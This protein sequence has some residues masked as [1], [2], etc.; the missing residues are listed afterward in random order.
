[1]EQNST[2]KTFTTNLSILILLLSFFPSPWAISYHCSIPSRILYPFFHVSF[3]H[4]LTNIWCLLSLVFHRN[5]RLKDI[6]ISYLIAISF[7]VNTLTPIFPILH[8]PTLGLSGL[9]FALFGIY[10][11]RV[12]SIIRYQIYIISFLAIT[13]LF[14]QLNTIIHVYCYTVGLLIAFFRLPIFP[15]KNNQTKLS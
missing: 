15:Y 10:A 14:P 3:F 2:T 4:A 9:C 12:S 13:S 1:M 5:V 8:R 11:L 6:I 7:P